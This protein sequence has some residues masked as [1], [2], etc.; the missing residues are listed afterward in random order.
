MSKINIHRWTT[1]KSRDL[2]FE[3]ISKMLF[4]KLITEAPFLNVPIVANIIKWIFSTSL[5][6]GM[7]S[8]VLILNDAIIESKVDKDLEALKAANKKA[9][10]VTEETTKE[11]KDAINEEQIKAARDLI[12]VGRSRV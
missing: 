3:A 6:K 9:K 1:P 12:R 4:A 5:E 8:I 7:D 10:E 2:A 11:E